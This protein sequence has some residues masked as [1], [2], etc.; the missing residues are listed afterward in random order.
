LQSHGR[1]PRHYEL[2]PLNIELIPSDIEQVR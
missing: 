2:P 1:M